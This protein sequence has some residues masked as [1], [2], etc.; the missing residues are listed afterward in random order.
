MK[1]TRAA[2]GWPPDEPFHVPEEAEAH[3]RLARVRGARLESEW[4]SLL[5]GYLKAHPDLAAQFEEAVAGRLPE[6]WEMDVPVFRPK[7]GPV[8]TRNASGKVLNALA[9]RVPTLMGGSADLAPSTKTL[10]GESTA[11]SPADRAGRNLHFGVRENAMA[12]ALNG[13]ALH[14]G[15][16]PYGASFLIFSDYARPSIRLSALMQA[17]VIYVFTHDSISVGEDGP[18][19]EP[20]EQLTSLRL[21]PGLLV[22]RPADANETAAAWR[23]A[24]T[25]KGPVLMALTRQNLPVL[26]P[27]AYPVGQGFS[28]GAYVLEEAPG[29]EPEIVLVASGSEVHLILEAKQRLEA[30]GVRARAVSMPSWELFDAQ[31]EEYRRA[32]L[33]PGVPKLAVE[34]GSPRGWRDYVGIEG[35]VIGLDRFGASAPGSLVMEK[36][37]F[38]VDNVLAHSRALLKK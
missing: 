28:H 4:S 38:T 8:A 18:T 35:D 14:G 23:T 20:V 33:P 22:L 3:L 11:F 2:F 25:W 5:R 36:L 17:H 9:K 32:V 13:M 12:A 16:I 19:H 30:E 29:D 27:D 1:A 6:R 26:D 24:L 15:V 21:I 10:I 37:G 31:P 34:A 7:D